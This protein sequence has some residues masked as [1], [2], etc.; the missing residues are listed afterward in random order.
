MFH[1]VDDVSCYAVTDDNPHSAVLSSAQVRVKGP[2]TVFVYICL[3]IW[4]FAYEFRSSKY[5]L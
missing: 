1:R 4:L 3:F 5:F 2:P